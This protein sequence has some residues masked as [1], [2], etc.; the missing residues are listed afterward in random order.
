MS[1]SN[2]QSVSTATQHFGIIVININLLKFFSGSKA[3]R[4]PTPSMRPNPLG[5]IATYR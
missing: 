2:T 4:L 3:G 5:G 1:N